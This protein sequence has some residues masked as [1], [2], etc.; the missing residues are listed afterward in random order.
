MLCILGNLSASAA[1]DDIFECS[2]VKHV[3]L[4][5]NLIVSMLQCVKPRSHWNARQ[6]SAPDVDV[7]C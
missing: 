7:C 1:N 4:P 5:L 2:S 3:I 6:C